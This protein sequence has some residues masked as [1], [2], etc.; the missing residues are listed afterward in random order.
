LCNKINPGIL[1]V[2]C[3]TASTVAL[4]ALRSLLN[5]PVAGVVP[6]IKPAVKVSRTKV[7]GLPATPGTVS[8]TYTDELI[9]EFATGYKVIK[10][11]G[12][13]LVQIAENKVRGRPIQKDAIWRDIQDMYE[14]VDGQ[15]LDTVVLGC[16]HFPLLQAELEA[17]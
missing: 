6:A 14:G 12:P 9:R 8:R 17:L 15:E 13:H 7:I 10:R 2:A 3:N 5:I 4:P 16:T 1:V 11:G